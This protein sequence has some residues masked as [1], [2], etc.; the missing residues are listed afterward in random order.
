M[1]CASHTAFVSRPGVPAGG[2]ATPGPAAAGPARGSGPERCR[3]YIRERRTTCRAATPPEVRTNQVQTDGGG[4]E[5]QTGERALTG[6]GSFNCLEW[7]GAVFPLRKFTL[8]Q[9][10]GSVSTNILRLVT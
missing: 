7:F 6:C 4:Q 1:L 2:P 8:E 5:H 10:F 3:R 9:M